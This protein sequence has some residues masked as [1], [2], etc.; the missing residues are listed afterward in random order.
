M[1]KHFNRPDDIDPS[2][3]TESTEEETESEG[4]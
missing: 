1:N 3:P 2:V 4:E